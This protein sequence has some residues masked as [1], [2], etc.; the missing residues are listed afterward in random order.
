MRD[1]QGDLVLRPDLRKGL[2]TLAIMVV[3]TVSIVAA[4]LIGDAPTVFAPIVGAVFAVL[5]ILAS[6]ALLS[7]RII[8]TAHEIVVRGLFIRQR[9][10]RSLIAEVVRAT[11]VAPR[12]APGES[13]FVLDAHRNLLIRVSGSN[14]TREDLDRLVNALGVPCSGPKSSVDA[15]KFAETYPGLVSWAE[16]HPYRIAFAIAGV[17]CA[18][19]MALVLISIATAS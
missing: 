6:G 10:S 2:V 15:N 19:V 1:V 9:R 5:I 11:I 7:A 13:L 14:Y 3:V 18:A 12:G 17:V 4:I 16:R 8:L